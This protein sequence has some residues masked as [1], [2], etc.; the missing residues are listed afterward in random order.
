MKKIIFFISSY[1]PLYLLLI[2]KNILERTTDKGKFDV[3]NSPLSNNYFF[4]EINDY[5]II[6]LLIISICSLLFLYNLIKKQACDYTYKIKEITNQT[7]EIYFNYISL[8]LLPCI[9]LSLNN[10]TDIFVLLFIMI[11]IGYIYVSNNLTF[12]NPV[13]QF[14]GY[15][16]Y[17][18]KLYSTATKKTFKAIIIINKK[19]IIEN[20]TEYLG[21]F[22]ND[23]VFIKKL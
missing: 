10:I 22:N 21:S 23:F 7:S 1:I 4:D 18:A 14:L 5:V 13:L 20:E 3:P 2:I 11:I 12:I 8:Y 6:F 16:I 15:N 19:I 17:D 9:G